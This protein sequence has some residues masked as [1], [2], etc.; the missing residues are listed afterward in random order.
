MSLEPE[1]SLD[2]ALLCAPPLVNTSLPSE[3]PCSLPPSSNELF[4]S[5]EA[6]PSWPRL[7]VPAVGTSRPEPWLEMMD[8]ER[9]SPIPTTGSGLL[10][11]GGIPD[12][13]S[14]APHIQSVITSLSSTFR[15]SPETSHPSTAT[16]VVQTTFTS[17]WDYYD[18]FSTGPTALPRAPETGPH[19]AHPPRQCPPQVPP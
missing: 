7:A 12:A 9:P 13:S 8:Q 4:K 2:E 14:L 6:S 15:T 3:E 10:P 17:R 5:S 19:N 18:V 16:A 11:L 1:L